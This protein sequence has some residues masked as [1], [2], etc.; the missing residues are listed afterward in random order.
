MSKSLPKPFF[1]QDLLKRPAIENVRMID[2]W[3][4]L[5]LCTRP[6]TPEINSIIAQAERQERIN[7]SPEILPMG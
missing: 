4:A 6:M 5:G 2:S 3:I 7:S 1:V